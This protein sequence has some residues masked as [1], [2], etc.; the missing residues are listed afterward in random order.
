MEDVEVLSREGGEG[1]VYMYA[2]MKRWLERKGQTRVAQ[3]QSL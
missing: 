2:R 3:K 1:S